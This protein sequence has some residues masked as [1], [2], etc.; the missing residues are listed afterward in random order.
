MVK[1]DEG[2]LE[3]TRW[4][5]IM[6]DELPCL[7]KVLEIVK[8]LKEGELWSDP[9]FGPNEK[10]PLGSKSM[11]YNDNDVPSGCPPAENVTWMRL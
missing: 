3:F 7:K 4:E 2:V 6:N 10:D 8:D 11:Y 5:T 1:N 9:E